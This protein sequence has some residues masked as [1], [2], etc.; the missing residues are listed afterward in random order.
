[1]IVYSDLL[2]PAWADGRT[3]GPIVQIRP[4]RRNDAGLLAHELEHV[5]QWREAPIR[6]YPRYLF[7]RRWRLRYEVE[8]FRAQL[9]LDPAALN[10][11]SALLATR[12]RLGISFRDALNLLEDSAP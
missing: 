2:L 11:C 7:S 12:Y 6:F 9:R 5:R 3:L 8:A 1:M 10:S 4:S